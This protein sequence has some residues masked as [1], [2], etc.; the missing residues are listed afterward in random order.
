MN[1]VRWGLLAPP[2]SPTDADDKKRPAPFWR[3]GPGRPRPWGATRLPRR[4]VWLLDRA[5]SD[6]SGRMAVIHRQPPCAFKWPKC[7]TMTASCQ[8]VPRPVAVPNSVGGLWQ[9]QPHAAIW[10]SPYPRR[11]T[12]APPS[13][14]V[15][16]EGRGLGGWVR[17]ALSRAQ[18]TNTIWN[19]VPACKRKP[20]AGGCGPSQAACKPPA[21]VRPPCAAPRPC[22]S[23]PR[24]RQC[25]PG[26][27]DRR[28][29]WAGRWAAAGPDP[30]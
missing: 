18:L 17:S 3:A 2:P 30:G 4:D 13:L 8:I 24:G 22:P 5:S 16:G 25:P 26:R 7:S 23:A 15:D 11:L 1:W 6:A 29:P 21:K 9:G 12:A 10:T 27:S 20:G 14:S 19:R 28:L